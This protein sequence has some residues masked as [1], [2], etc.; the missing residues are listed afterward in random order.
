M[1]KKDVT[2][3]LLIYIAFQNVGHV[4]RTSPCFNREVDEGISPYNLLRGNKLRKEK[5]NA[6]FVF[7]NGITPYPLDITLFGPKRI[8]F[9]SY[10]L[11]N[12][13]HDGVVGGGVLGT[14]FHDFHV[15]LT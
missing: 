7:R 5:I 1:W 12:P 15:L 4:P 8:V 2:P 11:T 13:I 9:A 3:I 10:G 6:Q 14:L